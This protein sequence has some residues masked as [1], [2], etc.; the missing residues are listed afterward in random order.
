MK[1]LFYLSIL[2]LII[3]EILNVYFI[4]PFPGSQRINSLDAAYFLYSWRWIFRALL[5]LLILRGAISVVKNSKWHLIALLPL[6]AV[7]YIFNFQFAADKMFLEP[8][9]ITLK[10]AAEN[11]VDVNRQIIGVIENSEAKAYPIQ[12]I[13][14][15]HKIQDTIG[16]NPIL[17]TYCTVCR[18]G[19]VFEP[20]ID[21]KPVVF[22]L[23]GM[24]KFNAMLE[25]SATESWWRQATG[26]AVEGNLKG[27]TLPELESVQSTL[28]EW[29]ELYPDSLIMQPDSNFAAEYRS[30]EN[31]ENGQGGA[32]T[33][34]N[35]ESWADKSLVVGIVAGNYAKAFDWNKLK[36]ERIIND[37]IGNT[38]VVLIL[39]RD[40]KSFFAFER[41][42]KETIIL[43]K[44][45]QLISGEAVYDLTG[46]NRN[47]SGEDLKKINAY[48]EFWHSWQSFHPNT[49]Y[50]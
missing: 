31:Y 10:N 47:Q 23:V 50:E 3:F 14:Y 34:A 15:H 5:G 49:K 42:Q 35:T 28:K 46:K 21:G 12:F 2:A 45:N 6:V 13:A 40:D 1:K 20:I 37:E 48:Q 43:L 7:A 9:Q 18:T 24:D 11:T 30:Y 26:E 16:G 22:R 4:M 25:D 27:Q 8:Q 33:G 29:L 19:R 39:A 36:R 44:D 17:V 32:L 38:P 41:P